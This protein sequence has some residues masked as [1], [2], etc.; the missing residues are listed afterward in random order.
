MTVM[1]HNGAASCL[2]LTGISGF[3]LTVLVTEP[4]RSPHAALAVCTMNRI[5]E[6]V[7]LGLLRVRAIVGRVAQQPRWHAGPTRE[8]DK[9]EEVAHGHGPSPLLIQGRVERRSTRRAGL[10]R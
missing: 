10:A 9:C 4:V 1:K 3:K 8:Y 2:Q 6:T 7:T 5:D